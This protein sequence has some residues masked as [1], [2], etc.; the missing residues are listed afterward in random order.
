MSL[1]FS[2]SP[3]CDDGLS[4]C[5]DD[6][7]QIQDTVRFGKGANNRKRSWE[8]LKKFTPRLKYKSFQIELLSGIRFVVELKF[9]GRK[10]G[11]RGRKVQPRRFVRW[12]HV[13]AKNYERMVANGL[14]F[15]FEMR[16]GADTPANLPALQINSHPLFTHGD[17]LFDQNR[18]MW[19]LSAGGGG[20]GGVRPVPHMRLLWRVIVH[21]ARGEV[22]RCLNAHALSKTVKIVCY[23]SGRFKSTFHGNQSSSNSS[24]YKWLFTRHSRWW[25]GSR[26]G[27]TVFE[28]PRTGHRWM[29]GVQRKLLALHTGKC[30]NSSIIEI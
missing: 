6:D 12:Y 18:L 11:G 28:R 26:A 3:L 13:C 7:H 15:A 9:P 29:D 23:F 25:F 24:W 21:T 2:F 4:R 17:L 5:W 1:S 8:R 30:V 27:R 19:F 10:R 16:T 20:G 22:T 14:F